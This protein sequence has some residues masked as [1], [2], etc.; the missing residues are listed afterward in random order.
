MSGKKLNLYRQYRK[1]TRPKLSF[2]M[3]RS[4]AAPVFLLAVL[5]LGAWGVLLRQNLELMDQADQLQAR[6]DDP[7]AVET[8]R[9]SREWAARGQELLRDMETVELLSDRL[10]GYPQIDSSLLD[11]IAQA[12]EDGISVTITGYDSA[13][14]ELQFNAA[15]REVIDIPN[16]VMDLEETGLFQAVSYTGYSLEDAGYVLRLNCALCPGTGSEVQE[17]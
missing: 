10:E 13:T 16:Y 7:E 8:A 1:L 17:A 5:L 11:R 3:L 14:G 2:R 12:G 9:Q 15:S 4:H 6:L